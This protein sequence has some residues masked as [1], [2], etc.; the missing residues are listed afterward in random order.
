MKKM[1]FIFILIIAFLMFTFMHPVPAKATPA[2]VAAAIAGGI[3]LTAVLAVAW[4]PYPPP[5]G[6]CLWGPPPPHRTHP[7]GPPPPGPRQWGPPPPGP[8]PWAPGTP[9]QR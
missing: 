3:I 1:S 7:W 2:G 6:P 5:P 9:P 8:Q 4:H